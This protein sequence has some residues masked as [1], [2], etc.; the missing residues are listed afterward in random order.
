[1]NIEKRARIETALY[2]ST[3]DWRKLSTQQLLD[4]MKIIQGDTTK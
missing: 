2:L 4:I 1:M 3:F